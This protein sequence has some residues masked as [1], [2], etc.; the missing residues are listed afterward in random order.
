MDAEANREAS[1]VGDLRVHLEAAN[2]ESNRRQQAVEQL[3]KESLSTESENKR[4]V[5]KLKSAD[6]ELRMAK[7]AVQDL[8]QRLVEA[9]NAERE[10]EMANAAVQELSQ[11][12]AEAKTRLRQALE[13]N[14]VSA[15]H[16]TC[17]VTRWYSSINE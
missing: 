2:E 3:R 10:R 12:L 1:R 8:S 15:F 4:L 16:R 9:E 11:Q 6:R 7:A 14:N 13:A 5:E 17:L